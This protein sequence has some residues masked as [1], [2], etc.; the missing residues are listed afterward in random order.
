M[1]RPRSRPSSPLAGTRTG[2]PSSVHRKPPL[3]SRRATA[4]QPSYAG[5]ALSSSSLQKPGSGL[6]SCPPC[7]YVARRSLLAPLAIESAS[8]TT[9]GPPRRSARSP[10]LERLGRRDVTSTTGPTPRLASANA[11]PR[12]RHNISVRERPPRTAVSAPVMTKI[13][14]TPLLSSATTST[15]RPSMRTLRLVMAKPDSSMAS[16]ASVRCVSSLRAF[17]KTFGS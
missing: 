14:G 15:L 5:S 1:D 13:H 16:S 6:F 7:A 9:L 8:K 3:R 17:S 2:V 10:S 11:T 4:R 12:A